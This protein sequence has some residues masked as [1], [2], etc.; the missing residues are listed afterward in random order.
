[1]PKA[2]LL[3]V[4]GRKKEDVEL[5][6]ELFG[7]TPHGEAVYLSV[8]AFLASLKRGTASTK[9]RS[10]V[11]GGGRKPWPQKGTGRAR[12]GSIRSPLFR[13]GGVIF[14]PKPRDYSIKVPKK[15]KRLALSSV[16]SSKAKEK[17]VLVLDEFKMDTPKTKKA[18]EILN[19]LRLSDRKI[20]L[21]ITEGEENLALSFRNLPTVNIV[22]TDELN[23]YYALDNDTILFTKRALEKLQEVRASGA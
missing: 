4:Q 3:T 7:I 21:V 1:M 2:P 23:A 6:K 14:G 18:V 11:R 10:E 8:R 20:T 22:Y 16:L 5:K 15:V 17:K 13:G 12:A 19:N 9:T